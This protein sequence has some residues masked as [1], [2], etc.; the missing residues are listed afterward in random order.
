M[1][2]TKILLTT[3]MVLAFTTTANADGYKMKMCER[4]ETAFWDAI[5]EADTNIDGGFVGS[6]EEKVQISYYKMSLGKIEGSIAE[7]RKRCKGIAS[8]DILDAYE[9]KKSQ[10]ESQISAL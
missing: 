3:L 2:L 4:A 9:K 7:V 10:I 1:K 8:K 5:A 6:L